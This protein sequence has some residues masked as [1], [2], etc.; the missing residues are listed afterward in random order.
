MGIGDRIKQARKQKRLTLKALG[1]LVGVTGGAITAWETGRN[2]PDAIMLGKL[3]KALDVSLNWL[4]EMPS[5]QEYTISPEVYEIAKIIDSLPDK[6][7]Q[8]M[9]NV[10]HALGYQTTAAGADVIPR[11]EGNQ[12]NR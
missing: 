11:A 3:A 8:T 5:Q 2:I 9:L 1:A 7:R 10:L 6:D 12:K 4:G